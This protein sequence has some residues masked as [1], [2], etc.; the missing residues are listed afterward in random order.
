MKS[1]SS[2]RLVALASIMAM[3]LTFLTSMPAQA[4]PMARSSGPQTKPKALHTAAPANTAV[5]TYKVDTFHSG[6]NSH[7]T[8]LTPSNVNASQFGKRASY[9]VDGQ[10]YTEPLYLPGVTM[11]NTVYNVVF[12]ATEND[13][14]YAFDAD[15][16]TLLWKKSFLVNGES[17][18]T[19]ND[20]TCNDLKP[21]IGITS[22]PVID[23][24]SGTLFLVSFT[25]L[26][27]GSLVYRLH[28]IDV[29]SGQDKVSPIVLTAPNFNPMRERQR[30]N[31]L[32]AN[33]KIYIGFASFCDITP[34]HGFIISYSYD[35][36]AFSQANVYNDTANGSMGGIWGSGGSLTADANGNIYVMTGNGTFDLNTGGQDAG[37]SFLKLSPSL[38]LLDY[39][40]PFNQACLSAT[41]ADLGS[42]SPLI[43]SGNGYTELIGEGKA[44]RTYVVNANNMGHFR[45]VTNPC[46]IQDSNDDTN[47]KQELPRHLTG[48][49][50]SAIATWNSAN[51]QYVYFG[52]LNDYI[53]ALKVNSDGT[54]ATVISSQTPET[55]SFT[56]GNTF[57]SSNGNAAGVLWAIDP[58]GVLRAYDAGNLSHELYNSN[59]IGTRDALDGYVKFSTPT[60]A[61][62][63]VFVGTNDMF[64]IFGQIE[65]SGYNS[66]GISDD[67]NPRE[68]NYDG[69]G[70]SYSSGAL[71]AVGITP[72]AS[73]LFNGMGFIW[74][75]VPS[76]TL[77]NYQAS[78]QTLPVTPVS[79]ATTLAF[80]GS[81]TDGNTSGTATLTYTD[82]S[83]QT[84]T[85]GLTD[86]AKGTTAFG[87]KVVA[88]MTYRN[89]PTGKQTKNVYLFYAEVTLSAGKILKSITLPA[90]PSG[91]NRL[92]I[93]AFATRGPLG[94]YNNIG[95]SN[96][97]D[98]QAAN[99][100]GGGNSYSAQ[101]LQS[102]GCTPGNN[103]YYLGTSGIVFQWPASNPGFVNNYIA[104][105][106]TLA[107]NAS[108]NASLLAFVGASTGG[109]SSGTATVNYSDKSHQTF[110]LGF[111]DWT[112]NG[113]K[114]QP[115][116]GNGIMYAMSYRNA[117]NGRVN[118]PTYVFV[119]TVALQQ[120]KIATSVTLPA[121]VNQ[122][123]MHIFALSTRS[124][125]VG[126]YNNIGTSDDGAPNAANFDGS[127]GS[128]S[129][130]ALQ[131]VGVAPWQHLSINGVHFTW[132]NIGSGQNNN[133][134]TNGVQIPA[135]GI[136]SV[137]NAT[138]LAFLGSADHGP[139]TV[140]VTIVY[141]DKTT[142][143]AQVTFSD[144]TL[145][146]GTAK[147]VA[148]DSIVFTVPYRNKATGQDNQKV[149]IFYTQVPLQAGKTVSYISMQPTA[150]QG[151]V[152][153]FA[154]GTK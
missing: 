111:S 55:Y 47:V 19:T 141:T 45:V 118:A 51:G 31:L 53:K 143:T 11:N 1:I 152:H 35:G 10:V 49:I 30:A 42:G 102:N 26:S 4:A 100:D 129:A 153:I 57:I 75:A 12:V 18:V 128:Y 123:Q 85:L 38:T 117:P 92:H 7:E 138:E 46:N 109:P 23:P 103:V 108:S 97:S 94:S 5:L 110:T 36:S 34:Y 84:F 89:S 115:A 146:A 29:T 63:E 40:T 20:V 90:T 65:T 59:Q 104:N 149:Y 71:K 112:L 140:T 93:F 68:A 114:S 121:K 39:F 74:P 69:G 122:G 13:S 130:Q 9:P 76:G 33:G 154:L 83:T 80:L 48:S 137:T 126:N 6:L 56:G 96:D 145:A 124:A 70:S 28:A 86:W 127:G 133:F 119:A 72:G 147:P 142:Q 99:F 98:P 113:G 62:G 81:S 32:L 88:T 116:F 67:G 134:A 2:Q 91:L 17:V 27:G 135:I 24:S 136:S 64:Y 44:E 16:G 21:I 144:W 132:P 78:G 14:L 41:D 79:Q 150:N 58:S 101:A 61:N 107:V 82:N 151:H 95:T 15:A 105:G 106:Q 37:D 87:N 148:G 43:L 50:Y 22:T 3:L 131:S 8:I 73:V 54:L 120:G 60:V 66:T 139:S 125:A 52:G 25:K 77:D